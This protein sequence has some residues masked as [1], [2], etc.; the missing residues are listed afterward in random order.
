MANP[1]KKSS[2]KADEA[3]SDSQ[4]KKRA[5]FQKATGLLGY[6]PDYEDRERE[7]YRQMKEQLLE[8]LTE[9]ELKS[10]HFWRSRDWCGTNWEEKDMA[11]I[12]RILEDRNNPP[13]R[14]PSLWRRALQLFS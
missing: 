7:A 1:K 13:Y 8:Q 9:E 11:R 12:K 5:L 4:E 14:K 3:D 6:H 10:Y 2:K